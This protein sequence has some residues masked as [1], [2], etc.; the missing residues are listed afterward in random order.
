MYL[1]KLSKILVI[2]GLIF[3]I[4]SFKTIYYKYNSDYVTTDTYCVKNI[5]SNNML[6]IDKINFKHVLYEVNNKY[7]NLK[8][9]LEIIK[10]TDY[11]DKSNLLMIAGHSGNSNKALF[12]DLIDLRINDEIKLIYDNKTYIYKITDYYKIEKT[13]Y[14][15][16]PVYSNKTIVLI[17]CDQIDKSKQIVYIG[18]TL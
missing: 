12:N 7:N 11:P 5:I 6:I 9:G 2:I 14:I 16:L 10:N 17:T 4:T 18:K 13:G 1:K 3:L 8:Y 15:K